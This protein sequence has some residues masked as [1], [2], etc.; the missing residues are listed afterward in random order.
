MR[1]I[2]IILIA[3]VVMLYSCENSDFEESFDKTPNERVTEAIKEYTETL[4]ASEHGWKMAY[5]V[6]KNRMG[7]FHFM[8]QFDDMNNV[9]MKMDLSEKSITSLYSIKAEDEVLL[10]F[11]T[12]NFIS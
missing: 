5:Y 4:T 7:A 3:S 8:M 12:Y 11:D 2:Y 9:K 10:S 1:Y 6:D